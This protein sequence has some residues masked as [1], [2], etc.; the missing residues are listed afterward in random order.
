MLAGIAEAKGIKP[1][2]ATSPVI[3]LPSHAVI[4]M[5]RDTSRRNVLNQ[6]IIPKFNARIAVRVRG[7]SLEFPLQYDLR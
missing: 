5:S 7:S 4:V 1:R 6:G 2:S 3:R